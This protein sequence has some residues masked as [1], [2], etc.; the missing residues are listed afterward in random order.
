MTGLEPLT[1]GVGNNP[2]TLYLIYLGHCL[3]GNFPQSHPGSN[4]VDGN[5]FFRANEGSIRAKRSNYDATKKVF[6]PQCDQNW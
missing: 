1:F 3:T 4:P 2:T 6:F 5:R